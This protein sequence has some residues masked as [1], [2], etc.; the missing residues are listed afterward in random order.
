M[1]CPLLPADA[2]VR[3]KRCFLSV[4]FCFMNTITCQSGPAPGPGLVAATHPVT[5]APTVLPALLDSPGK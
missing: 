2:L 3:G 4:L 1:D 5:M